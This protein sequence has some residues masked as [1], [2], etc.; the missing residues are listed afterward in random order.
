MKKMIA[1]LLVLVMVVAMTACGE[2]PETDE[3]IDVVAES[4]ETA[5]QTEEKTHIVTE[6]VW[7]V[8]LERKYETEDEVSYKSVYIY[9]EMGRI[10]AIDNFADEAETLRCPSSSYEYNEDGSYEL[11]EGTWKY[12]Y[13]ANGNMTFLKN[14][15][16]TISNTYDEYGRLVQEESIAMDGSGTTITEYRYDD[17]GNCVERRVYA[18]DGSD[19]YLYLMEYDANGNLTREEGQHNG[20]TG[21]IVEYT[22]NDHNDLT[23]KIESD[24]DGQVHYVDYREYTYDEAGNMLTMVMRN[25]RTGSEYH[26]YYAYNDQGLKISYIAGDEMAEAN[27]DNYRYEYDENGN[28]IYVR[29]LNDNDTLNHEVFYEYDENGNLILDKTTFENTEGGRVTSDIIITYAYD[30]NGNKTLEENYM[31]GE[32]NYRYTWEYE[33]IA[34]VQTDQNS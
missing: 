9:D 7:M 23:S 33:L 2:K 4:E 3:N 1:V 29:C 13:D 12:K 6:D 32:F 18:E 22:Y 15:S 24:K 26:K 20:V 11:K 10:L 27:I 30:E 19:E 34:V 8:T 25:P 14:S 21:S 28:L 16:V 17:Q 5:D 31:D